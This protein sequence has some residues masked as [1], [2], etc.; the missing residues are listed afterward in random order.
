MVYNKLLTYYVIT[1]LSLV[2]MIVIIVLVTA[3][4]TGGSYLNVDR[5]GCKERSGVI[6]NA[7]NGPY[8]IKNNS[9]IFGPGYSN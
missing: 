5:A 2:W 8:C 3:G 9:I 4:I 6:I 1:F 7:Y